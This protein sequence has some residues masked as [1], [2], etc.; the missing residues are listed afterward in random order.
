MS[1]IQLVMAARHATP[2]AMGIAPETCHEA[3]LGWLLAATGAH[4]PWD[5]L[6]AIRARLVQVHPRGAPLG[7]GTLITG[8]WMYQ[9]IYTFY[10]PM[11]LGWLHND[12][13]P[14]DILFTGKQIGTNHSMV[15]VHNGGD[16]DV[17]IRGFNNRGSFGPDAPRDAYDNVDRDIAVAYMWDMNHKF[18]REAHARLELNR[19]SYQTAAQS[20]SRAIPLHGTG[21]HWQYDPQL[22]WSFL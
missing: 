2:V 17:K 4:H 6:Q 13:A 8:D 9:N 16:W 15:V 19:V 12:V 11:R 21:Q 7:G 10:T 18:G 14:G 5:L 3:V 22:G 20:L 1:A